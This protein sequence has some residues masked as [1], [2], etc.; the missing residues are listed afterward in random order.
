METITQSKCLP[1]SIGF[2]LAML[3]LFNATAKACSC[4]LK[5]NFQFKLQVVISVADQIVKVEPK[6]ADNVQSNQ[7]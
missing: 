6:Y 7:N 3:I 2:G 4:S 5:R 1:A